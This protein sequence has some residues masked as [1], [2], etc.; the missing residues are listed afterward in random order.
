MQSLIRVARR[1]RHL[2]ADLYDNDPYAQVRGWKSFE[3]MRK[4]TP[5][6]ATTP[7]P[8]DNQKDDD[9]VVDLY[10]DLNV[11]P[12]SSESKETSSS[13]ESPTK[14]DMNP[15]P[16]DAT[17]SEDSSDSDHGAGQYNPNSRPFYPAKPFV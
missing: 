7:T 12:S 17:S 1:A 2:T 15:T 11:S 3:N 13:D 4:A 14:K 9:K 5:S 10:D 16:Y 8:P 6:I